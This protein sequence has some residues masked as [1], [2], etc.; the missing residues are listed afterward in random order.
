MSIDEITDK[1][2]FFRKHLLAGVL[3]LILSLFTGIAFVCADPADLIRGLAEIQFQPTRLG[4]DFMATAGIGPALLNAVLVGVSALALIY[5]NTVVLSGPTFA[6][7]LTLIGF[8]LFGKTPFSMAPIILGVFVSA[9]IAKKQFREY[10]IIALPSKQDF[11]AT[12]YSSSR[13]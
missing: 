8:S 10:I 2:T 9:R 11:P 6:T 7:V 13:L 1:P 5:F 12:G 3:F 4:S